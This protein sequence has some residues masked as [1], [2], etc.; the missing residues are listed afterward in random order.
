MDDPIET[1]TTIMR[2]E[3]RHIFQH[4][5]LRPLI[6]EL[7]NEPDDLKEGLAPFIFEATFGACNGERLTWK[8]SS[9]DIHRLQI[10][11]DNGKVLNR[12]VVK[13]SLA[14]IVS[15]CLDSEVVSLIR[16]ENLESF[17]FEGQAKPAHA[18][19]QTPDRKLF[20][21]VFFGTNQPYC[22]FLKA[23]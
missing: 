14:K 12:F 2:Q 22:C 20:L 16:P 6:S 19:E 3:P 8:A 17:L 15:V 5:E 4:Q 13:R 9:Q 7:S 23:N 21:L 1:S 10:I 18:R 11:G